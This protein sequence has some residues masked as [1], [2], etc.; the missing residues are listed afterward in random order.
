MRGGSLGHHQAREKEERFSRFQSE[1]FAR[2]VWGLGAMA[3]ERVFYDENSS[4]VGGDVMS[5]TTQAAWMVGASAM[6]TMPFHIEPRE[7][8]TEEQARQRVL[9][10]FEGI[11]LN[12]MNRTSGGGPMAADPIAGVLSDPSKRK[13]AAQLLGQAYV[14]A[15]HL[16][17]HNR[18]AVE[19]TADALLERK[20]LFGDELVELLNAQKIAIPKIDL[21]D[22]SFW[23]PAFF[24]SEPRPALPSPEGPS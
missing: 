20:E 15:H 21:N 6:G 5:A 10:R 24:S 9:R 17:L 4:G 8:E 19:N 14:A 7:D 11:G 13:V 2:L 1:L 12:I 23:P 18:K 22:E 16:V 3:A